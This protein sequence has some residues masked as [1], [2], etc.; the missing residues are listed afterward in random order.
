[1]RRDFVANA[2]HELRTPLTSIRGFVEALEDGA[3]ADG[4]TATRFLEKIRTHADRMASLVD[5]LLAL[6]RL[7]SGTEKP[8]WEEVSP[9][10]VVA[11]VA[12]SFAVLAARK[13]V[14]LTHADRAAPMVVTD[15][16]WL[17]RILSNLVEN[18]VKYTPDGGMVSVESVPADGGAARVTVADNGPGV[19]PEHLPRLF[20]R[21]YRVDKARSRELGGTGLGLS[22]VKHLAEGMGAEVTVESQPGR[23]TCFIVTLP[24]RVLSPA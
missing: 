10:E 17:R 16:D 7:E 11:D 24:A 18:A 21:F 19:A 14:T 2:S 9:A 5:D 4:D 1:V 15:G 13:G 3:M 20:E 22:I 23:G 6:S 12:A 8:T